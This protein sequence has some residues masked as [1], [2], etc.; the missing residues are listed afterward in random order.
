[1]SVRAIGPRRCAASTAPPRHANTSAPREEN[2]QRPGDGRIVFL[3]DVRYS[4]NSPFL[5]TWPLIFGLFQVEF[6]YF[7]AAPFGNRCGL[8]HR[9]RLTLGS[10]S[11]FSGVWQSWYC[12]VLPQTLV[13]DHTFSARATAGFAV[14]GDPPLCQSMLSAGK[15]QGM[16]TFPYPPTLTTARHS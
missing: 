16:G 12:A 7:V 4:C 2:Q 3:S 15:L 14:G 11:D 10:Y 1:V 8:P 9:I 13:G 5:P 6:Y